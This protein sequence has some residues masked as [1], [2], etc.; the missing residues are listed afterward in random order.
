MN[1]WILGVLAYTA[2]MIVFAFI[3]TLCDRSETNRETDEAFTAMC[4]GAFLP[5]FGFFML[6]M[7]L[8]PMAAIK[9]KKAWEKHG[10]RNDDEFLRASS[11][12]QEVSGE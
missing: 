2:W 4:V 5:P 1:P 12:K 6:I 8:V 11:V 3:F 9:T 7:L 10:N